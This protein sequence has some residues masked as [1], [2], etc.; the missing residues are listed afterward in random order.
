MIRME[1]D[2][3]ALLQA[4]M[5]FRKLDRPPHPTPQALLA[6]NP[7]TPPSTLIAAAVANS[8]HLGALSAIRTWLIRTTPDPVVADPGASTGYWR[9]TQ[10][11]VTHRR[12]MGGAAFEMDPD[13]EL[14]GDFAMN[15]DDSA[16]EKKVV[17]A[18]FAYVRA[19]RF[20]EA[21]ALCHRTGHPWR[22][23]TINGA[24]AFGWP[25]IVAGGESRSEDGDVEMASEDDAGDG[26]RGNIRRRL[27]KATCTRAALDQSLHP[28]ERALYAALA[29][30]PQT[31][32]ALRAFCTSWRD[33][34]WAVVATEAEERLSAMLAAHAMDSFWEGGL[35]AVDA[36]A[37]EAEAAAEAAEEERRRAEERARIAPPKPLLGR[38]LYDKDSPKKSKGKEK[39]KE[40]EKKNDIWEGEFSQSLESLALVSVTEG[41]SAN[42]PFYKA[43]LHILLGRTEVLVKEFAETLADPAAEGR[44]DYAPTVRF[45]TH[46][47]LFLRMLDVPVPTKE[48]QLILG[49]YLDMLEEAGQRDL[50]ALYT[51]A[52]GGESYKRYAEYLAQFGLSL[53]ATH[54]RLLLSR[55]R[56]HSLDMD[57]I[58]IATAEKTMNDVLQK[59]PKVGGPLPTTFETEDTPLTEDEQLLIRSLEWTTFLESTYPAA[60]EHGCAMIR[61]YLCHGRIGMAR[62]VLSELPPALAAVQKPRVH[63]LEYLNYRQF[64][65]AWEAIEQLQT[66]QALEH[67]HRGPEAHAMWIRDLQILLDRAREQIFALFTKEWLIPEDKSYMDEALKRQDEWVRIRQTY[68]PEM[69]VRL[70]KAYV[71]SRH[72]LP[73][74]VQQALFLANFV[75]DGRYKLTETF[76][77]DDRVRLREYVGLLREAVLIGLEAGGSDPLKVVS[78]T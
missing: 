11:E 25:A 24:A 27:W 10:A 21:S 60:L 38:P 54:R 28:S 8:A 68:G 50:I 9:L 75:A 35:A 34:L 51:S 13:G 32:A 64:F 15:V 18:V 42:N 58:A 29:P 48:F 44:P 61:Y 46:L 57:R 14:R 22:A 69:I 65:V 56:E 36:R 78:Q 39:E 20:Q 7:Y 76:F 6:R 77:A 63:A 49:I 52:L 74:N 47:C 59:M 62:K 72:V 31:L 12:R 40:G 71:S 53:D 1:H 55:A 2:T 4:L 66:R 33:E 70:H 19:G 3:W 17:H 41:D 37:A 26:A 45:F 5:P 43:Q 73:Q 16:Y 23:A 30:S 67:V